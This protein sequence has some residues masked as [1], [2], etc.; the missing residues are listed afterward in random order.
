MKDNG[1]FKDD[2]KFVPGLKPRLRLLPVESALTGCGSC[3]G[4][5]SR[6]VGVLRSVGRP[7]AVRGVL[8]G[9]E[10]LRDSSPYFRRFHLI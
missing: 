8:T 1:D 3:S 4:A 5:R 10:V 7:G 2:E 9:S 6:V